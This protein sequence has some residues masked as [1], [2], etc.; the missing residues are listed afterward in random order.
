ML[1]GCRSR[2]RRAQSI[3]EDGAETPFVS[4]HGF[5]AEDRGS[6]AVA[7]DP[8]LHGFYAQVGFRGPRTSL[9]GIT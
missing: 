6:Q 8:D 4:R 5:R 2:G 9:Y 7:A 3:I 1:D